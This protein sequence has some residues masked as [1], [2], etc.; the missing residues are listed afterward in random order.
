MNASATRGGVTTYNG[1]L[2]LLMSLTPAIA[3]AVRVIDALWMAA[4]VVA[5]LLLSRAC[6]SLIVR[7]GNPG[8]QKDA[9]PPQGR[10]FSAL[11]VSSVLTAS[12]EILLMSADPEASASLGIYAP[13]IAVNFLVLSMTRAVDS[14]TS[15]GRELADALGRGIG[16]AACLI[17]IAI[18]REVLG[19]GTMTLFP[20]GQ[21][22]GVI[23]VP[24]LI[25]DPARAL[26]LAGGGLICLGYLAALARLARRRR[27]ESGAT[28]VPTKDGAR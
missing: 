15:M 16:F 10:F 4:G 9:S 3:V 19:A 1:E 14:G 26:G 12:F 27:Q 5:V 28:G 13:L 23:A 8:T 7:A 17:L 25:D 11:I 20:V 18:L 6:M 21:F 22:S 2:A 24:G